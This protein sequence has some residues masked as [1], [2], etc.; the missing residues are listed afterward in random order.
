MAFRKLHDNIAV[1]TICL[2][3]GFAVSGQADTSRAADLPNVGF[4]TAPGEVCVSIAGK[5]VATYI[6]AKTD[7]QRRPVIA[8]VHFVITITVK[9]FLL[10]KFKAIVVK[11]DL[12][13]VGSAKRGCDRSEISTNC[14]PVPSEVLGTDFA[15]AQDVIVGKGRKLGGDNSRIV[16]T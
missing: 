2:A 6:H 1:G 5:P 12:Q 7:E 15:Q 16:A 9:L 14:I 3:V 4:Q 11:K 13:S 8:I 10:K